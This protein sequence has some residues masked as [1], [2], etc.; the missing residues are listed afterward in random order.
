MGD[1]YSRSIFGGGVGLFCALY[2]LGFFQYLGG[3]KS[4]SNAVNKGTLCQ[5]LLALNDPSNPYR[6]L[7]GTTEKTDLLAEWKIVDASWY[8]IFNKSHLRKVYRA[9]LLL[10]ESRH[11]VRCFEVVGTV[12]WTAGT[13]GPIPRV[14]YSKSAFG[15]R[16]LFQK[17]YGVGYGIKDLKT[18][19]IKKV[20]EYK[21]DVNEI[22]DPITTVVR[23][24]GWEWIPVT[25]RRHATYKVWP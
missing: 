1:P 15:G 19:K 3:K 20:Y 14:R 7:E 9:L 4:S 24:N 22:R 25:A 18:L 23:E 11:S 17:S 21:F 2:A 8:G 5:K 13:G 12:S 10:D 6:I 16:I